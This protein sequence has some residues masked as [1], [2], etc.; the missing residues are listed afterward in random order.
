MFDKAVLGF[1]W[2]FSFIYAVLTE[3]ILSKKVD[4]PCS[5]NDKIETGFYVA[6]LFLAVILPTFFG[7]VVILFLHIIISIINK[8]KKNISAADDIRKSEFQNIICVFLLT[9]IFLITYISSMILVEVY[10]FSSDNLLGFVMLKYVAGTSHH[11][12]GPVS[13]LISRS[14]IWQSAVQV[15]KRGGTTQSKTFE[16]T[17]EEIKKELGL[18]VEP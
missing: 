16:I 15:Y 1:I 11:L 8:V 13:I 12:L 10:V 3:H 2:G 7:P 18:G 4:I 9:I 5:V 14:D 17:A 6:S